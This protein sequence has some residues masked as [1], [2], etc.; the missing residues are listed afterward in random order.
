MTLPPGPLLQLAIDSPDVA[1]SRRLVEAVYPHFD[2]LEV[3]TPLILAEGVRVI[4]TLREGHPGK[5]FLA[6]LKIMD[7]GALEA[8]IAFQYGADIVTVLALA[9]DRT[10]CGALETAAKH[11]G[12]IM[13]DL[14][15]T[16]NQIDRAV[17]LERLGI[18][19]LCVHTAYDKQGHGVDPLQGLSAIRNAVRCRIAVA[20]GLGIEN[21]KP[22]IE[23]GADILIIGGSIAKSP[24]P[25]ETGARC[26]REI[27][28]A[29]TCKRSQN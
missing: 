27:Q 19:I 18:Q 6:D 16:S 4:G 1:A 11:S 25:G 24:S 26:A 23:R 8:Q 14:I 20:G 22:A 13:A 29:T 2:I 15:N 21:L 9:D 17:E 12:Q 7:A 10:I 3:G 5:Q 28:E